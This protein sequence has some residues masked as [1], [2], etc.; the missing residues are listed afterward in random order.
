MRIQKRIG[1]RLVDA[2][3]FDSETE[4]RRNLR[5]Q[6]PA[7]HV[8]DAVDERTARLHRRAGI[9][10]SLARH[11]F[12]DVRLT[13]QRQFQAAQEIA[14][15]VHEVLPRN[16]GALPDIS[17]ATERDLQILQC[18][19]PVR[20]EHERREPA[21]RPPGPRTQ[22]KRHEPD[23]R[24]HRAEQQVNPELHRAGED[25]G[26]RSFLRHPSLFRRCEGC[27]NQ[28]VA[29]RRRATRFKRNST[30][31]ESA[32]PTPSTIIPPLRHDSEAGFTVTSSV[33]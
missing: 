17:L 30:S 13:H 24:L 15:Q 19:P 10:Q 26:L 29:L 7:A 14:A 21:K 6:F 2:R 9:F 32:S 4:E 22:S 16:L 12:H 31:N 20:T 28:S 5:E 25:A 1:Q 3:R 27:A 18:E 11:A 33:A 23:E 8:A